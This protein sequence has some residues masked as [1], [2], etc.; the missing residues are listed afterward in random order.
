MR[1]FLL[2]AGLALAAADAA[3]PA[4]AEAPVETDDGM[5]DIMK[6]MAAEQAKQD[7]EAA[8]EAE[9]QKAQKAQKRQQA[10]QA[11]E[12]EESKKLGPV[13]AELG[14]TVHD[15]ASGGERI[16][17]VA[18]VHEGD[19][20]AAASFRFCE[21]YNLLN[22]DSLVSIAQQLQGKIEAARQDGYEAAEGV[23]LKSAGAYSKRSKASAKDGEHDAAATD[24]VRA[25]ARKGILEEDVKEKMARRL[26]DAIRGLKG[27]REQEK[28]ERL[29]EEKALR[30]KGLEEAAMEEAQ[31]RRELD[32]QD[33]AAFN[34]QVR[35]QD[36]LIVYRT[37]N[38]AACYTSY[39]SLH[40]T[41]STGLRRD[42]SVSICCRWWV[43]FACSLTCA[44]LQVL[45]KGATAVG[46]GKSGKGEEK[47][48]AE[49]VAEVSL[50]LTNQQVHTQA[51]T[52]A[53]A[54][55]AYRSGL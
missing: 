31:K 38:S 35:A 24:L 8:A 34:A 5:S 14:L 19:D 11:R 22:R 12:L 16:Q 7:A 25:L 32:E 1:S 40:P 17:T 41:S 39:L 33:W 9:R 6:E 28:K 10:R 48:P 49:V 46:G 53:R 20:A 4:A 54:P 37:P 50:T 26:Q 42:L 55:R 23:K 30:R 52:Q 18:R 27:Q 45:G 13:V 29:A 2:L 47:G 21:R 36:A 43:Q 51:R 15:P 3:D 44:T